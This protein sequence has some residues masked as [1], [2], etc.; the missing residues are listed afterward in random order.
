MISSSSS[1]SNGLLTWRAAANNC[2]YTSATRH[3]NR[4]RRENWNIQAN[5]LRG[6]WYHQFR[7]RNHCAVQ[8]AVSGILESAIIAGCFEA[9]TEGMHLSFVKNTRISTPY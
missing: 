5:V 1:S 9:A 6:V 8:G 3:H 7:A 4:A 2:Q